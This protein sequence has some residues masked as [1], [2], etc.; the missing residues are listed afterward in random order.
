MTSIVVI[1]GGIAGLSCAWRLSRLPGF[2]VEVLEAE[3]TPGGRMRSERCGDFVLDRGVATLG[4]GQSQVR[5]LVERLGL[6]GDL[7][8]LNEAPL[9]I[10]REGRFELQRLGGLRSLAETSTLSVVSRLK[11][12]RLGATLRRNRGLL[13][14]NR[15][16]AAVALEGTRLGEALL[17]QVGPE[18][19]REC[20]LPLLSAR[21]GSDIDGS[22]EAFLLMALRE[23][24]RNPREEYL[25]GGLGRIC[26][27]LA[28][29]LRVRRSCHVESVES[30]SGGVRIR[31]RAGGREGSVVAD[32]AVLAVPGP[33]VANICAKL[34]PIE[35]GFFESVRY[36][37]SLVAH[38]LYPTSPGV[39]PVRT[40]L[41]RGQG[42]AISSIHSA[43]TKPGVAPAGAGLLSCSLTGVAAA[44]N[45]DRNDD[46][47]G[48][49][50]RED[51]SRTPL[52]RHAPDTIVVHR[53]AEHLPQFQPGALRRLQVFRR[54]TE[55][56][57]RLA[58]CGDYLLGPWCDAALASGMA[59]AA[60]LVRQLEDD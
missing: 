2:D 38:A 5:G 16:E 32:A 8:P 30:H 1:G 18:A 43:H 6:G 24:E 36:S 20:V 26:D 34:T 40:A 55:R 33:R 35:R 19:S 17:R 7:A 49:L 3:A 9:A 15:P 50:I 14:P 52:G 60:D 47:I 41:P 45:W 12:L 27:T 11:L 46:E 44:R 56:S 59:A 28:A 48:A 29:S 25:A 21:Y 58:F 4:S 39:L 53:F 22:S 13:D 37:R 42:F 51:L 57:P 23:A 31:Y 54:R 10:L